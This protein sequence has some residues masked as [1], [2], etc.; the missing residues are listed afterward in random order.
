MAPMDD[1][2]FTNDINVDGLSDLS[3]SK[4]KIAVVGWA[5]DPQ[6]NR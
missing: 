3:Q 2:P 4:K 1:S 6:E 5:L